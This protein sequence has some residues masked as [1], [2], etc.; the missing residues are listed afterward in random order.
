MANKREFKKEV[1]LILELVFE[2]CLFTREFNPSKENEIEA[3]IQEAVEL[4][5]IAISTK[6]EDPKISYKVYFNTLKENYYEKIL[7]ILSK[8][9]DL[10]K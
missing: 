8:L 9:E 1:T 5:S 10:R 6:K 2:E 4:Y 7:V 3:L